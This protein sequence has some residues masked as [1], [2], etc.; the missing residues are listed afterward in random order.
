MIEVL[1]HKKVSVS[2]YHVMAKI[3]KYIDHGPMVES[4]QFVV[5]LLA[6]ESIVESEC[7]KNI[8]IVQQDR[9]QNLPIFEVI[10]H[11]VVTD[12][13]FRPVGIVRLS[14]GIAQRWW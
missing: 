7:E 2:I 3:A 1:G 8:N 13:H 5:R 10:A 6:E 14:E 9:L 4:I 11:H 12:E